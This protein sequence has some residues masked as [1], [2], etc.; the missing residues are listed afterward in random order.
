MIGTCACFTGALA[1]GQFNPVPPD[2]THVSQVNAAGQATFNWN[3][4]V[5]VG[6]EVWE[7][8]T[9]TVHDLDMNTISMTPHVIQDANSWATPA[10]L[11]DATQMALCVKGKLKT[12]EDGVQST[13]ESESPPMCSIHLDLEEGPV[14]ETVVLEWNSPYH[15]TGAAAGS[16]FQI[17]RLDESGVWELL[18][19]APDSPEGGT[20]TDVPGACAPTMVYRIR[21][22]ASDGLNEHVSNESGFEFGSTAGNS[23]VITHVNVENGLAR[24]FW[25]FEPDPENLGYKVFKCLSSGSAEVGTIFDNTVFDFVVPSSIADTEIEA[26]EVAAMRCYNPDGTPSWDAPSPCVSTIFL[27]VSQRECSFLADL[28]W[29][30]P[31]GMDGGV[32]SYTAQQWDEEAQQWFDLATIDGQTES[33]VIEGDST[34]TESQAFRILATGNNGFVAVSSIDSLTFDYPDA[35]DAPV[36]QRVSVLDDARVELI[37]ATDEDAEEI[38]FYEFQRW[39][40]EENDWITLPTSHPASDGYQVTDVDVNL[41]T[42]RSSYTY[43]AVVFNDCGEI[44]SQSQEAST[45]WLQG[46]QNPAD[47]TF[48]NSLIWTPY[49][50]FINGLDRYEVIR[51][52]SRSPENIGASIATVNAVREN[53][54]DDVSELLDSPGVFCYRVLAIENAGNDVVNGAASNWLC[55]TEEPI[56]WIPTAFSPNG[57]DL[58]DWFPWAPGEAEVGF[59]GESQGDTPNFLMNIV[60]RWGTKMYSTESIEEPWDGRMNGELVPAGVYVVHVQYLDGSGDWHQQ[61]LPLT[62]LPGE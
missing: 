22:L 50:G 6:N 25:E 56:V 30:E 27:N 23:P 54:T 32:A 62:V 29:N 33:Y 60:S 31:I 1:W 18:A 53:H 28:N 46:F 8:N 39:S 24:V 13:S 7:H 59:L 61:S 41:R 57:D 36:L 38:S 3:P 47:Q 43:R 14:P 16:D 19:T 42:D 5:P 44:V 26:Y 58:N 52:E 40:P 17:E 9:F 37:L 12:L 34:S 15:V 20:Y 55:L 51:K 21:Q 11:Y 48:E 35:P 2:M 45:I 10:F 4:Y 49:T